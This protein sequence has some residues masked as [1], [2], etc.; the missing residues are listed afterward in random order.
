MEDSTFRPPSVTLDCPRCGSTAKWQPPAIKVEG[1]SW[2]LE[3]VC[4]NAH[5]VRLFIKP[6]PGTDLDRAG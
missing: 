6:K 1:T 4:V 2:Q 3:Y 5:Q